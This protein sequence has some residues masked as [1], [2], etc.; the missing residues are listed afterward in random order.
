MELAHFKNEV[1]FFFY[2]AVNKPITDKMQNMFDSIA[3]HSGYIK[4]P[5]NHLN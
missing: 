5:L 1:R 3:E 4:Y 2:L